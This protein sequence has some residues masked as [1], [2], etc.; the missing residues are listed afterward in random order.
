MDSLLIKGGVP[1][2][3]E[4]KISGAKNAVLP[5]MAATLLTGEECVIRRVPDLSDVGFMAKILSSLGARVTVD[6][7]TVKV[8]AGKLKPVGNYDLI[9]KMR[10]VRRKYRRCQ[11]DQTWSY[12][13]G[14]NLLKMLVTLGEILAW[15]EGAPGPK[16]RGNLSPRATLNNFP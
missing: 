13:G 3:G 1:L 16:P 10:E 4:V 7:D 14:S 5:I 6:G 12:L 2:H 15:V 8:R 11:F 9:R